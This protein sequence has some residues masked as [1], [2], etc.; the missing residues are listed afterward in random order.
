M[1][2]THSVHAEHKTTHPATTERFSRTVKGPEFARARICTESRETVLRALFAFPRLFLSLSLSLSLSLL[3]CLHSCVYLYPTCIEIAGALN[4]GSGHEIV[5]PERLTLLPHLAREAPR[6]RAW[7]SG[8]SVAGP[9]GE[10][11]ERCEERIRGLSD[12]K[13]RENATADAR[14]QQG[15]VL[16]L[17]VSVSTTLRNQLSRGRSYSDR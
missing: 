5:I 11:D 15:N 17:S 14:R 4:P 9:T 2:S 10:T 16:W 7:K 8:K 1:L 13:R 12:E 3:V 6:G